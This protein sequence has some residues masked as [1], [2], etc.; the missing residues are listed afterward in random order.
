LNIELITYADLEEVQGTPGNFKVTVRK[1]ARSIIADR[2]TGCGACVEN[3]PVTQQQ[4]P[5]N[6]P[7]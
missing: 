4:V 3:C 5:A 6:E 1:R 2:C 7:S